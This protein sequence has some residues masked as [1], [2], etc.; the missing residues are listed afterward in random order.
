VR[1]P[2]V[3]AYLACSSIWGTT[4]FAIRVCIGP[5]GYP[6]YLAAAI[7]FVI[8]T[9]ILTAVVRLGG[10]RPGPRSLAQLGWIGVA[11]LFVFGSYALIYTAEQSIPGGLA[12]VIYG[13][14]PLVTAIL[15]AATGTERASRSAVAGA[16]VS[17]V[18]IGIIFWDRLGVS[19]AQATGVAL[20]FCAVVLA[21]LFNI[22]I[23]RKAAGVHPL[24]QNA[25]VLGTIA[26][27][28]MIPTLVEHSPLPWPPPFAPTVALFYLAVVG[29]VVA[30]GAYFYL[31][32]H[33]PLMT[34]STTV[35]VQPVIALFVDA[36]WETQKIDAS[37]YVGAAVTIAGVAVSFG[38]AARRRPT[39]G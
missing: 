19:S 8:A 9:L 22:V 14:Q 18:G 10:A 20:V 24:V 11:G 13:T 28:M 15:T 12:C 7:R 6:T 25:W 21:T 33:A 38:V 30:F 36:V 26:G 16:I 1:A 34:A 27:A 23:K 4:Y 32:Q 5:G 35:L 39:V 29:S 17:L 37:S 3:L 31:I 2:V